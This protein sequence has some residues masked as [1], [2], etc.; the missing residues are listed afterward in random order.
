MSRNPKETTVLMWA[1]LTLPTG[2]KAI[3]APVVPKRNPVM[4]RRTPSLG[5]IP[6]IGVPAPNMKVT[7][8]RP[9]RTSN[10]VPNSSERNIGQGKGSFFVVIV[11]PGHSSFGVRI[12][13][14]TGL[15]DLQGCRRG[16]QPPVSFL[17]NAEECE[18]VGIL[19]GGKKPYW[20]V[21]SIS[22]WRGVL[23]PLG[24]HLTGVNRPLPGSI[25]NC[26]MLSSPRLET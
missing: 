8:D 13:T 14:Q 2:D 24:T 22:K 18:A 11:L 12:R 20:P 1:P 9:T 19:V 3:N 10:A 21:G 15:D 17:L 26:A 25:V 6:A 23:P 5:M 7:R 4:S 16:H